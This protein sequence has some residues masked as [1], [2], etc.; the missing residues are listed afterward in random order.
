M[1]SRN[2]LPLV[3]LCV[4]YLVATQ[5]CMD[6]SVVEQSAPSDVVLAATTGSAEGDAVIVGAGNISRCAT[7]NDELTAQL[8]DAIPGTVVPLG[9]NALNN[10]LLSEYQNCYGP[11]WG[12]HLDRTR[13]V[14]GN[15]EYDASAAAAGAFDYFGDRLGPRP[16]GYY[17][18]DTGDWHVIVLNDNSSLVPYSAGSAQ[19]QWLVSDLAA[20]AKPCTI[21]MWHVPLFL[22]S[23]AAGYTSNPS[24][25]TLWNRLYAAGVDVVL[26]AQQHHYE[27][28]APMRP[29]GTRDDAAGIRQFNV[30]TGGDALAL[31]TVAIH[32]HSEIRAAVYGVLKLTLGRRGY[33]WEFIPVAGQTFTDSGS[34]TCSGA[35]P[36]TPPVAAFTASCS[37][38]ACDFTD[39]S[40]DA[41]GQVAAWSWTFGDGATADTPT[42]SHI[43][44][45]GG[46]Y[47]VSLTVTDD[48]GATASTSSTVTVNRPPVASAGGPYRSEDIVRF[49]GSASADPDGDTQLTYAWSFGDGTTGTGAAPTH[50]YAADGT[51]T[52]TLTVTDALGA[53]SAPAQTTAT[54]E[55]L[56]PMVNAGSDSRTG[57]GLFTLQATFSD[58]GAGD[59]PWTYAINWGDGF[60]TSG[61]TSDQSAAINESHLY[62]VPGAYAVRVTVTDK[63]GGIGTDD[64]V[65]TVVLLGQGNGIL[66]R[67]EREAN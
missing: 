27:R 54:I 43:Y 12:R 58:P 3:A 40:R 52:V 18:Y 31:P 29:D 37:G 4:F 22:S 9:D 8:L 5:S 45:T 26:N 51:Y 64:L 15:H 65:V 6:Q 67:S 2:R 39:A 23:N 42:P 36:N 25:T 14:L 38:L 30:G 17:S 46:P 57:P 20:N 34:G 62:L 7:N 53:A 55:N 24:R 28:M 16:L 59:A 10:G 21:A 50:A 35:E 44:A 41:E 56:P 63:D 60:S 48:E 32:P 61:T 49:D 33:S 13:P 1:K 47:T 11:T 66:K 19:D